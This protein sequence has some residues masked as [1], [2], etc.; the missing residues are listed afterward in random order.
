MTFE[1][2][3]NAITRLRQRLATV[4][5]DDAHQTKITKYFNGML[6]FLIVVSVGAVML[7]SVE[8]IRERYETLFRII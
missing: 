4:F 6:A 3:G 8:P 5:D 2:S 1:L 7:E